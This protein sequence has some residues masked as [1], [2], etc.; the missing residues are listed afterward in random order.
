MYIIEN[1]GSEGSYNSKIYTNNHSLDLLILFA[2]SAAREQTKDS[3][4]S[5]TL[6][7][8]YL[9]NPGIPG[10]PE[11]KDGRFRRVGYRES[12]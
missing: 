12:R 3:T 4:N 1:L 7:R 6:S 9:H 2:F 10:S 5:N 8:A 11:L